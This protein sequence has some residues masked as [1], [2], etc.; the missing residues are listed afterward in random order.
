VG[1]GF[2]DAVLDDLARRL[3]PLR[4]D[5]S[6][7][8]NAPRLP[9]NAVFVEPCLVAE[10]EFTEWTSDHVMRAPSFKGLREDKSP[11]DVVLEDPAL[12]P[13]ESDASASAARTAPTSPEAL[14]DEV[15]RQPDGSLV[16]LADGR[17][18]KISNWDKVLFPATGFT[19]GDLI[20]YYARVAPA[21]LPHLKDR[22]LTLKRYPG[23]VEDKYF[24][25]KQSPSH[26]PEWVQTAKMGSIDYTVC[27]DRPTLIWLANLADI[28]LHTSLA[29]IDDPERPTMVVFDLDPGPPAAIVE[30]C[31]VALVLRGLFEQLGLECVVKTSGSKGIQVYLPLN[32][33]VTYEQTKPFA[34]RIAELLEQRMPELVVSR[35]TKRIRAGKVLVDWSQNAASKTTV[36]VYSVRARERPTV[37]TPVSWDEIASCRDAGDPE[38]LNFETEDV[39]ARVGELGDLF[40]PALSLKQQLPNV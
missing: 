39:L 4:R 28:E 33:A 32:T 22:F 37:S 29:L 16:V 15:E 21:V 30:C 20:A 12:L 25:E 14:F 8:T 1:T 6:P 19:K 36:T 7:F 9:R 13:E 35:M 11:R 24:Y 38:L 5:S 26:R 3:Q 23:G 10:I 18:I 34:R 31:E 40:A 2:T 17:R 27:Q